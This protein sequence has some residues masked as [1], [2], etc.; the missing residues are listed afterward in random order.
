M[1]AKPL[2]S[3]ITV[4]LNAADVIDNL[5]SSLRMQSLK[6]FQWIIKD[7]GSTDE[8]IEKIQSSG[9]EQIR[10]ISGRD[11]GP[12]DAMNQALEQCDTPYYIVMGADDWFLPGALETYCREIIKSSCADIITARVRC[13]DRVLSKSPD[14]MY[15]IRFQMSVVSAHSV[16]SCIKVSLH[17]RLGM[18]DLRYWMVADALFLM[19]C[20]SAGVRIVSCDSVVGVFGDKGGTYRH[21]LSGLCGNLRIQVEDLGWSLP[22]S[23]FIFLLK[24]LKNHRM[25]I[26]QQ[27]GSPKNIR[28]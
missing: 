18:Y 7:G 25:I 12:Y 23:V 20:R 10:L 26:K 16:G 21:T 19:R 17:K 2:V 9:I 4:T 6:D 28:D 15:R 1:A 8:T 22:I 13:G 24:L 14:W 11:F 27:S 5:I 3:V